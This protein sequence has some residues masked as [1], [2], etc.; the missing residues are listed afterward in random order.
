LNGRFATMDYKS[1]TYPIRS[2]QPARYGWFESVRAIDYRR[3]PWVMSPSPGIT[4]SGQDYFT[5]AVMAP[6]RNPT[7]CIPIWTWN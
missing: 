4:Y 7:A 3:R 5:A 1:L 6:T 2:V